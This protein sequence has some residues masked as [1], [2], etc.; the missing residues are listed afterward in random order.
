MICSKCG[1][2]RPA[3]KGRR[4]AECYDAVKH[5]YYVTNIHKYR[6]TKLRHVKKH[7]SKFNRAMVEW[8]N[9]NP[10]KYLLRNARIR[11]R[12]YK[13]EFTIT[14]AD[15]VIPA[16]CPVFGIPLRPVQLG[17]GKRYARFDNSPSVDRIDSTKG[18]V[19]GNVAVISWKANRLKSNATPAELR[20]LAD[21]YNR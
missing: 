18:Y 5:K 14:E 16:N 12:S 17:T 2:D 15:V 13:R 11:A 10:E 1:L 19:P 7:Q 21:F 6:E 4:C 3:K 20:A 8:Y 9:A